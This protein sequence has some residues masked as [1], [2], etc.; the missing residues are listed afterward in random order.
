M[1]KSSQKVQKAREFT[2]LLFE[3]RSELR[4]FLQKKFSENND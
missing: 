3:L 4:Q 1:A 2:H